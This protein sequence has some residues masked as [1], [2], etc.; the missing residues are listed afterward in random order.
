MPPKKALITGITGQDGSYLAELLLE[1][2]YEVH[3]LVRRSSS[4]NRARIDHLFED[5][6]A[7]A[8]TS[9]PEFLHYGDLSDASSINRLLRAIKPDEIYNLGAQSHVKVSFEIPEYTGDTAGLGSLRILEGDAG[10]AIDILQRYKQIL[11]VR[12]HFQTLGDHIQPS[13]EVE[14]PAVAAG[15]R[16]WPEASVEG[17]LVDR[18][19]GL[20]GV[21]ADIVILR[22][23]DD[24]GS[25]LELAYVHETTLQASAT[26]RR[27]G[28]RGRAHPP[29]VSR[30]RSR[31]S[32]APVAAW[33]ERRPGCSPPRAPG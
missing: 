32:R 23:P 2:G 22:T 8:G 9:G 18:I 31:S 24:N 13:P 12:F 27:Y 25:K 3:G 20:E 28:P 7:T 10:P 6:G 5:A 30:T 21:Q 29:C 16:S 17:D 26:R 1:K 14:R 33:V 11:G 4:L 19:N 15:F